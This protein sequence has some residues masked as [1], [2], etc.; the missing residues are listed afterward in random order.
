M[1]NTIGKH[2]SVK[3]AYAIHE[4]MAEFALNVEVGSLEGVEPGSAE[5]LISY[6]RGMLVAEMLI[7]ADTL[8]TVAKKMENA[9]ND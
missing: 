3:E 5:Y 4:A 7:F 1:S 6:E 9:K 8:L 2:F